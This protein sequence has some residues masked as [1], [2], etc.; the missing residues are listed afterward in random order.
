MSTDHQMILA[1][2][3]RGGVRRNRRYFKVRYI[4]P[5]V[6]QKGDPMQEPNNSRE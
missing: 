6:A 4:C 2:L 3:K 1:E 5:I